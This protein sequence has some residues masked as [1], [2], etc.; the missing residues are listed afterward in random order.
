MSLPVEV[1]TNRFRLVLVT[2]EEAGQALTGDRQPNWHPD[3]PRPDDLDAFTMIKGDTSAAASWGPRH[4]VRRFDDLVIGGI[5][6]FGPPEDGEVEIGYG[7]VDYARGHGVAT[8]AVLA[9]VSAAEGAGATVRARTEPTN[10][11]SLRV[12]AKCGFTVLRGPDDEGHLVVAR[13]SNR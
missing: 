13:P 6:F 8:E 12:L 11:A 4:I 10:T 1:E 7:L 5:G 3:Y 9:M 2:P